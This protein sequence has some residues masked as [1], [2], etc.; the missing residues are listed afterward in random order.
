MG[1]CN[2]IEMLLQLAGPAERYQVAG[3]QFILHNHLGQHRQPA[4]VTR[5]QSQHGHVIDLGAYARLDVGGHA[6]RI[7]LS[8]QCVTESWQGEI[9]AVQ[10][11]GHAQAA[12]GPR[13]RRPNQRDRLAAKMPA[14]QRSAGI[15]RHGLIG[16]HHVELVLQ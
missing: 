4:T 7:E 14:M 12:A 10:I 13:G 1:S 16:Q 5:D 8:A 11:V 9:H 15:R 2:G 3:T 6:E